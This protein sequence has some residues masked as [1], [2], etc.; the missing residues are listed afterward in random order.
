MVPV[1]GPVWPKLRAFQV[2]G[3]KP[4]VGKSVISTILC[5]AA[6]KRRPHEH[7][8]YLEPVVT[9]SSKEGH[10]NAISMFNKRIGP[11]PPKDR[12]TTRCIVHYHAP[13]SPQVAA[14]QDVKRTEK[15]VISDSNLISSV[16]DR[17]AQSAIDAPVKGSWL[18]CETFGG[19]HTPG[20][21]GTS[22]V[23]LYR[24]LRLPAI[25]IG[26][27]GLEGISA[28]ISAFESLRI[29]GYDVEAVMLFKNGEYRNEEY[30]TTYFQKFDIPCLAIPAPH[31][32]VNDAVKDRN[33]T[34]HYMDSVCRSN[35]I[36]DLMKRLQKRHD[37]RIKALKTMP[38]EA[39]KIIWYPS[40]QKEPLTADKINAI[41]SAYGDYLQTAMVSPPAFTRID[42][43]TLRKNKRH[44]EQEVS[45]SHLRASFDGSASW[46]TKGLGHAIPQLTLAAAYAAGRYGHGTSTEAIYQ[47]GLK[48]AK[49]LLEELENP[50]LSR[51]FYSDNETTGTEV[52][53]KMAFRA[54]RLRYGWGAE[55]N[56]SILGLKDS[57]HV[58]TGKYNNKGHGLDFPT[59][60]MIDG[61]WFVDVP[62]QLSGDSEATAG[63][64]IQDLAAVFD[65]K[66][67][68]DS[69]LAQKYK[70]YIVSTLESLQKEGHNFGALLLEPVVLG[71]NGM[72]LVDPLFLRV[73][74]DVVRSNSHLFSGST[75]AAPEDSNG[76]TGLPVI[77]DE[78]LTGL[79]RFGDYSSARPL[80]IYSDISLHAKLLTGGLVPLVATAASESIFRSL[81]GDTEG[82]ALL[83]NHSYTAHPIGCEVALES[84][85][86][87][88][89]LEE[90]GAW[91]KFQSRWNTEVEEEK[92]AAVWSVWGKDF[93]QDVSMM[94]AKVQSVWALGSVLAIR[95]EDEIWS[96][97]LHAELMN[98]KADQAYSNVHSQV[99]GNVLYLM[100]S[101]TSD[102]DTIEDVE[103]RLL[104][105]KA[106]R[107]DSIEH[108]EE[109]EVEEEEDKEDGR[110]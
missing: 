44:R 11:K 59:I 26:D 12:F 70:N 98:G 2:W 4:D 64:M 100:A 54:A 31:E 82:D 66:A 72:M 90:N 36:K 80:G 85:R 52:A 107:D 23:D 10:E 28:T 56:L 61:Q 16:F 3:V 108:D 77:F 48:L 8:I 53:V 47:P 68:G 97:A 104:K 63:T 39:H 30:L 81:E 38:D 84:L 45:A 60:K 76:W 65:I 67:R 57:H 6:N 24:P 27:S 22:Q 21:S 106:L 43:R 87:M 95:F 83:Q 14:S 91:G 19:V 49:V 92:W 55:E 78:G 35:V 73:Y 50:R 75:P 13:G 69:D 9:D 18:F 86:I 20:P 40:M 109:E 110:W 62:S 103:K 42:P 33:M 88:D 29:R 74:V 41:D 25:L 46:W 99:A 96:S 71:A 32:R 51:V 102:L 58:D 89:Q 7:A 17:V 94:T 34:F 105:A 5:L 79:Y 1:G 15:G 93:V 37:D 101:Q